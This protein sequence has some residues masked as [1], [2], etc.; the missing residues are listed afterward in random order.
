MQQDQV[1][2]NQVCLEMEYCMMPYHFKWLYLKKTHH[3]HVQHVRHVL[4]TV[5]EDD[6]AIYIP[7]VSRFLFPPFSDSTQEENLHLGF[8]SRQVHPTTPP[9]TPLGEFWAPAQLVAGNPQ[10]APL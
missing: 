2:E 7:L 10:I 3:V 6:S 4:D 1:F 8:G 9:R 5:E